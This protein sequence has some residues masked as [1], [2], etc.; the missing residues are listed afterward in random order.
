VKV[1]ADMVFDLTFPLTVYVVGNVTELGVGPLNGVTV[2]IV[3]GPNK[4][5]SHVTGMPVAGQY[6]IDHLV[7]RAVSTILRQPG[8]AI[9][10]SDSTV[11]MSPVD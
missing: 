10:C 1:A 3:S 6:F 11:R 2:E 8:S 5:R 7:P 4:G 9:Y